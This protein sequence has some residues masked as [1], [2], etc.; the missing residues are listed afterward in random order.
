MI[1][2]TSL[3]FAA[4]FAAVAPATAQTQ[5]QT[6]APSVEEVQRGF[7]SFFAQPHDGFTVT[8]ARD[9]RKKTSLLVRSLGASKTPRRCET[10]FATPKEILNANARSERSWR[11]AWGGIA[12]IRRED[13]FRLEL[14]AKKPDG[15]RV[16]V[17]FPDA[18]I[19]ADFAQ[20]MD[21]LRQN[22]PG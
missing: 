22:C 2:A 6:P 10:E 5:P 17:E 19:A 15:T 16:I 11:V 20:G 18:G 12:E 1:R 13:A 14:V 7:D 9:D 8:H 3:L 21:F 4:A